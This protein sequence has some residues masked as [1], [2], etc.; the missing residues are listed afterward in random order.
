MTNDKSRTDILAIPHAVRID[1]FVPARSASEGRCFPRL[2]FGLVCVKFA[3][4]RYKWTA[5]APG[6][7]RKRRAPNTK[8]AAI[9]RVFLRTCPGKAWPALFVTLAQLLD[10]FTKLVDFLAQFLQ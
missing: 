8:D 5:S 6:A 3:R 7:R 4:E 9:R 10:Q 1:T 2:R